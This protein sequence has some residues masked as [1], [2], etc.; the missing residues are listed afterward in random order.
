[1][2]VLTGDPKYAQI[3]Y[4]DMADQFEDK[5]VKK[6]G[7]RGP[8]ELFD[9][10]QELLDGE[11]SE[12][13][14][15]IGGKLAG[16]IIKLGEKMSIP[17]GEISNLDVTNNE[18]MACP[19]KKGLGINQT[20]ECSLS[21]YPKEGS[22]RILDLGCGSGLVGKIFQKYSNSSLSVVR[23]DSGG[24]GEEVN[25][26]G[27]KDGEVTNVITNDSNVNHNNISDNNNNNDNTK[28][29][30]KDDDNNNNDIS[31]SNNSN[32]EDE[33]LNQLHILHTAKHTQGACMIGVDVSMRMVEITRRTQCYTACARAD[34]CDA[35]KVFEKCDKVEN[36]YGNDGKNNENNK[37]HNDI[38][39]N[40]D[41]NNDINNN[42]NNQ[43]N[44]NSN[45]SNDINRSSNII[46]N[47]NSITT[48][49]TINTEELGSVDSTLLDMI[50]V[51]DTFI[52]VGALGSVF[53]QIKQSLKK[54]GLFLFSIEDLDSSPMKIDATSDERTVRSDA[55]TNSTF[56]DNNNNSTNNNNNNNNIIDNTNN[57]ISNEENSSNKVRNNR[58]I[59]MIDNEIDGA[60]PGWGGQLLKSARFAHSNSY[61]E[62]LAEIH[63]FQI[64]KMKIVVLR[65]E[66][67]IPLYGR[68]YV[69][70][71]V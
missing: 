10:F 44:S 66:E 38:S 64:L 65:T 7:Y 25:E 55:R 43:S 12:S 32:N 63:G 56:I 27:I 18:K 37:N 11:I 39:N 35:L 20:E 45:N 47:K 71:Y 28:S 58:V 48:N 69:L 6:L 13:G 34:L 49:T 54:H 26:G 15:K 16:K 59:S 53:V 2:Y 60:V 42:D 40:N 21:K 30:N 3:I 57:N 31:N 50:I 36:C 14:D 24:G 46:K 23:E 9:L 70:Q 5:L 4:D 61:I 51:A 68:L 33:E 1:M 52:Y 22:W 29:S 17:G 8:W 19:E 62:T 67:T 41:N